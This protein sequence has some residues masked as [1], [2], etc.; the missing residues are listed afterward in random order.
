MLL[1]LS[2][3]S[4]AAEQDGVA[5]TAPQLTMPASQECVQGLF[6]DDPEFAVFDGLSV[7]QIGNSMD[8]FIPSLFRCVEQGVKLRGLAEL[9]VAVGCDGR[10]QEIRVDRVENLSESVLSC[11]LETMRYASFPAHDT[12][13]GV[14][15]LYPMQFSF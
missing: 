7:D 13:D 3:L 11:V 4:L 5:G 1:L 8:A 14:N 15:F 10:V 2:T 12:P 9:E 6:A